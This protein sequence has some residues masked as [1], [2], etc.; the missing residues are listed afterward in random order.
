MSTFTAPFI[1][2]F[3]TSYSEP[4]ENLGSFGQTRHVDVHCCQRYPG[5][6]IPPLPLPFIHLRDFLLTNQRT[7]ILTHKSGL[8]GLFP[9]F[10]HSV[11]MP[12]LGVNMSLLPQQISPFVADA[13]KFEYDTHGLF[14]DYLSPARGIELGILTLLLICNECE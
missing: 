7:N 5:G 6:E 13:S 9:T 11:S 1:V 12:L 4:S 14:N 10:R 3:F 2:F 8:V